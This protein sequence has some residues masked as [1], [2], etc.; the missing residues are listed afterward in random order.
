MHTVSSEK[1]GVNGIWRDPLLEGTILCLAFAGVK[2]F[3]LGIVGFWCSYLLH[4]ITLHHT[5]H[6]IA[7]WLTSVSLA[8][9][10]K[11]SERLSFSGWPGDV[12]TILGSNIQ[13]QTLSNASGSLLADESHFFRWRT[14][15]IRYLRTS[16]PHV[17][18]LHDQQVMM[19][20][21]DSHHVTKFDKSNLDYFQCR[22][23][24][25]F[26]FNP[27]LVCPGVALQKHVPLRSHWWVAP[28]SEALC[29]SLRVALQ[30]GFLLFWL[31]QWKVYLKT[32]LPMSS[33]L[34]CCATLAAPHQG[35]LQPLSAWRTAM[36]LQP[37]PS[38]SLS[39][40]LSDWIEFMSRQTPGLIYSLLI[41]KC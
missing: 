32:A 38:L 3:M 31:Q 17:T 28:V 33:N 26:Q 11:S 24:Q 5:A 13:T 37:P 21:H 6:C 9:L 30:T 20:F 35:Y 10:T 8:V 22:L 39:H 34:L 36:I 18:D 4:C 41:W 23:T 25:V 1:D 19:P 27:A 15:Y 40:L 29:V 16:V 14:L 12:S 7:G 2:L